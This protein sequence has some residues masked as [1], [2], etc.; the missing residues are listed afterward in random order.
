M[1]T[2]AFFAPRAAGWE[3]RFP[4]DGPSSGEIFAIDAGS[5]DLPNIG[6]YSV[7]F[8]VSVTEAGQLVLVLDGVRRRGA[9]QLAA[10]QPEFLAALEREP[11]HG[12][13]LLLGC[14]RFARLERRLPRGNEEHGVELELLQRVMG[15]NQVPKMHGIERPAV[16]AEAQ[17]SFCGHRDFLA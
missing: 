1:A 4:D 7:S 5:F 6:T 17:V 3:S 2:R 9:V 10:A 16:K 12:E 13:A 14:A 11:Q 8:S 15:Q